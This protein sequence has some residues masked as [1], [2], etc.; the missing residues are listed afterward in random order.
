VSSMPRSIALDIRDRLARYLAGARS[1]TDLRLWL[2][3][4]VWDIEGSGDQCAVSL[5][6]ALELGLAEYATGDWTEAEL[7]ELFRPLLVAS[8]TDYSRGA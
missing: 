6:H 8:S 7:Q 4:A 1:L 2:A 5:L 3:S